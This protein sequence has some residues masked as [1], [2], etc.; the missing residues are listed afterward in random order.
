MT[1]NLRLRRRLAAALAAPLLFVAACSGGGDDSEPEGDQATA[2][3]PV[4]TVTGAVGD[5]PV[6]EVGEDVQEGEEP[7]V[8]VLEEGDGRE[9][10]EGDFLRV[11]ILARGTAEDSEDLIN[12]WQ[13]AAQPPSSE[14][15]EASGEPA[16]EEAGPT[17]ALLQLGSGQLPAEVTDPLVGKRVGS[18]VVVQGSALALLGD[19]AAQA[20]FAEGDGVVWVYDIAEA[21]DPQSKAEGEQAA[22]AE[23]MP[24][25]SAEGEA[26]AEITIPDTEAPAEL[27]EQVLIEGDGP[28]VASGDLLL[29][30]YTGVTW[31]P[32]EN[33][34]EGEDPR[35]FDSSWNR[36]TASSFQIGVGAVIPGWDTGLVGKHVG[37]RVL[38]VIPP[39]QAY[40]SQEGHDLATHTLVFV[41]DI[42]A[43][44]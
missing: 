33:V 21:I 37:D 10:A 1:P 25:V 8:T 3:W 12:S 19:N 44:N 11:A 9:V 28:E 6:V 4:A 13:P 35:L 42:L 32:Q 24:E 29:V 39:D 14:D 34:E 23:G 7:D 43:T 26:P 17:Y 27:Q 40:G 22:P 5:E 38:L 16:E 18:R 20:G 36:D 2:A 31:D 30:Q 41:V 15:G